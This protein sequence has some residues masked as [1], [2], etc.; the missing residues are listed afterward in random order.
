[1]VSTR[2][3]YLVTSH[4]RN[5]LVGVSSDLHERRND[6]S[7]V[8]GE[9]LG[10]IDM[11]L[12]IQTTCTW[13]KRPYEAS[14]FPGIGFGLFLR[15]LG[16]LYWSMNMNPYKFGFS[17]TETTTSTSYYGH[18]EV[19]DHLPRM[20]MNRRAWE[21]PSMMTTEEI[22]TTDHSVQHFEDGSSSGDADAAPVHATLEENIPNQQ[23]SNTSS[24]QTVWQDGIDPDNMTYEKKSGERCVI[25][26]MRYK[27]GDKQM[28]LPCKHLYHSECISK[29]LSIN[30]VCPVCNME[31]F[32]D[33][34]S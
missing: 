7:T 15:S 2:L 22:P 5:F 34:L 18:Y 13:T 6:L 24:S 23:N 9:R 4:Y 1:M 28:K 32:G 14:L 12:K 3:N 11:S 16:K 26:Q 17:G 33:E 29:W 21:Y 10:E 19:N 30:K 20:D 25:C 8:F 27:R 31:V